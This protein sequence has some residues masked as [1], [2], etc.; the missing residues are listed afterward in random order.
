M[1]Q[2]F[3]A[4]IILLFIILVDTE[5]IT[6]KT[7][8]KKRKELPGIRTI[9]DIIKWKVPLYWGLP[10]YIILGRGEEYFGPVFQYKIG[11]SC[12]VN[13]IQVARKVMSSPDCRDRLPEGHVLYERSFNK[14]L[15]ILFGNGKNWAVSRDFA[16]KTLSNLGFGQG[17]AVEHCIATEMEDILQKIEA[18]VQQECTF[19][20]HGFFHVPTLNVLWNLIAGSRFS[21]NDQKLTELLKYFYKWNRSFNLGATALHAFPWL[22]HIPKLTEHD[23]WVNGHL[24]FSAFFKNI[25]EERITK[26]NYLD[27]P[28]DFIDYYLREMKWQND[29]NNNEYFTEEQFLTVCTDLFMAG[30]DTTRTENLPSLV[31]KTRMPYTEAT[32]AEILRHACV[33]PV[34]GRCPVR[35]MEINEC[36]ITKGSIIGINIHGIH[37]SQ[38]I[39]SDPK[40]F[41][42]ERF[43]S[44][45]GRI[46]NQEK[47]LP[48]GYGKRKCLGETTSRNTFFLFFTAMLQRYSF[49]LSPQHP[50]PSLEDVCGLS[51]AP[52]PYYVTVQKRSN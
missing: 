30:A 25:M 44:A 34:T 17:T 3:V 46:I 23:A 6:W 42:P 49:Q 11:N 21:H 15:G 24:K 38:H 2:Y 14:P 9:L 26:N 36:S 16:V 7:F 5:F 4:S 32:T 43:L 18:I 13:D 48:F 47:T 28:N 19:Q 50:K 31:Y 37:F 40:V 22:R 39:W 20:P 1:L 12:T 29:S 45:E 52:K 10:N 27:D 8:R 33:I 51:R 35:D 41:R